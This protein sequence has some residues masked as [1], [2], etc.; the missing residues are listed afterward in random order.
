[1]KIPIAEAR[2]KF[3]PDIKT[4][5]RPKG[6]RDGIVLYDPL[7]AR[8][9][10][11][12]DYEF[13]IVK[14]LDGTRSVAQIVDELKSSGKYYSEHDA[15]EVVAKADRMGLLV[16]LNFSSAGHLKNV[17]EKYAHATRFK[18][19]SSIYFLFIPIFNPDTFL[20]R[21][22]WLFNLI[23]AKWVL[24]AL[25]CTLPGAVY[26]MISEL[27]RV[28]LEYLFFFNWQN[29][30]FLWLTIALTKLVHE[31]AHA[32]T[33]KKFGLSVPEMGIAFLVFFPCLYC[34]TTDAWQLA[35]SRRRILISAAGILAEG[36]LATI[37]TYVWYFSQ[38]G[39]LN[40]LAFYLMT[41]SFVS[42]ILFNANPLMRFDGY[43]LLTDII[44]MPN[45]ANNSLK[46]LKF[47][48]MNRVLGDE[49]YT[50]PARSAKQAATY[51]VY[52]ISAFIYRIF[53][54]VSL[55]VGVYY[56]FDKTLGIL[57][58]SAAVGLFIIKPLFG[59]LRTVILARHALRP[60]KKG[61][62][63][64]VG[65]LVA[66][67]GSACL[68]WSSKTVYPCYVSSQQVRKIAV[69]LLTQV[70]EVFI[71]DGAAVKKGALLLRLDTTRLSVK[72][73]A[74]QLRRDAMEKEL[75]LMLLDEKFMSKTES[76]AVEMLQVE[77]EIAKLKQEL[78]I[79]R[80]NATAPFDGVVSALDY[81]LQ[82]GFQPGEG[83]VVGEIHSLELCTIHVLVPATEINLIKEGGEAVFWF[84][85]RGG[86]VFDHKIDSVKSYN[87]SD[88]KNSPFSSRGG[89]ELATEV[90]GDKTMDVPLEA[91]YDCSANIVNTYGLHLGMT[92]RAAVSSPRA[93][94]LTRVIR[95]ALNTFHRESFI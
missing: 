53:L 70:D 42:T 89:G 63:I 92:G 57:L 22:V 25:V 36:A 48:F 31:F 14:N 46:H 32:Y 35:D 79:A 64:F 21:T 49:S 58:A 47:M 80:D 51:A 16:G 17:K 43:F 12:S 13:E 71:R 94:L 41:V 27:P 65:L 50:T 29:L 8:Y 2:P 10:Q 77:D 76:K 55:S 52:G 95:K 62:I 59:G 83:V 34:N 81:R 78:V 75:Q 9:F 18:R 88:L 74:L 82:R 39:L 66:A 68:P 61:G 73:R 20:D 86:L 40:S 23:S 44:G 15:A 33:A 4:F 3:R 7:A 91:Q 85:V 93:S 1:M 60:R 56:R 19:L 45:L 87:E 37:A 5:L 28:D 84:P 54:Y 38:P 6:C 90:R 24:A 26:M 11:V 30:L 72:L 69:P 67:V